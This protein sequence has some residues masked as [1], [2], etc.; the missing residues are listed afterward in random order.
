MDFRGK[1]LYHQIHPLEDHSILRRDT[2]EGF[3]AV[4]GALK[5]IE[6]ELKDLKGMDAELT[7]L[8]L[9]VAR[10]ERKVGLTH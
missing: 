6:E 7:A 2:E 1:K 5:T 4:T 10:V 9:R 8:R 3:R